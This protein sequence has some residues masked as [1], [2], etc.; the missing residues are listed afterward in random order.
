MYSGILKFNKLFNLR[1]KLEI[2]IKENK[3][4][5]GENG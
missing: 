5:K 2:Y 4:I 3:K 1:F